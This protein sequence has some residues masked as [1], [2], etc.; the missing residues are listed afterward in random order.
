[1]KYRGK[2]R[3]LDLT[4]DSRIVIYGSKEL[5][6]MKKQISEFGKPLS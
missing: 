6:M 1:M 2:S 3:T 4:R 5:Q